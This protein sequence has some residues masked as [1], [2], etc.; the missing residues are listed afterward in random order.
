MST[1]EA[2]T[3]RGKRTVMTRDGLPVA[4][5]ATDTDATTVS[6]QDEAVSV[7]GGTSTTPDTIESGG[8]ISGPWL[9]VDETDF[10]IVV[11]GEGTDRLHYVLEVPTTPP[12]DA[13]GVLTWREFKINDK[14]LRQMF[15]YL[16]RLAKKQK[17]THGETV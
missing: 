6:G 13:L 5:N 14:H 4:L 15:G 17:G 8:K 9:L 1:G 7:P 10:R 16:C 11:V 2:N 3:M 12:H